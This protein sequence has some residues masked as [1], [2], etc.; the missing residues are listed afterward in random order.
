LKN[1]NWTIHFTWVKAHNYGNELA[2]QLAK[3]AVSGSE[4]EIAYN[5][6]PKSAVIRELHEEGEQQWQRERDA[7]TKGLITKLFFPIIRDR[8]SKRLQVGIKQSTNLTGHGALRAYYHRFKIIDD[9]KCVCKMGPQTS[10]YLLWECELLRKQREVLKNRIK[11]AGGN[12]PI[13]NSDLTNEYTKLFQ[14]F[15]NSINFENL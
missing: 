14:K 12:W 3:E 15:V 2:D 9:L 13:T 1:D 6:I 7:S 11:K 5:K 10:D 4:A 8:L